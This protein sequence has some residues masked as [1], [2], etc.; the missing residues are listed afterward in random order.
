MKLLDTNRTIFSFIFPGI[1]AD[2]LNTIVNHADGQ[3]SL[4]KDA[5]SFFH[6]YKLCTRINRELSR[7]SIDYQI[8]EIFC[9][10]SSG[11]LCFLIIPC[12][13]L[14]FQIVTAMNLLSDDYNKRGGYTS[15][16][17]F[18]TAYKDRGFIPRSSLYTYAAVFSAQISIFV[19][20]TLAFVYIS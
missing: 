4:K 14:M 9:K 11:M 8:S 10:K 12:F 7:R 16:I 15:P 13:I 2:D 5:N 6:T 3:V 19:L 17:C 1:L 18:S 20:S